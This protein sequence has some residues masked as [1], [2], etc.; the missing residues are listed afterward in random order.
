V[1]KNVERNE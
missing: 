1:K